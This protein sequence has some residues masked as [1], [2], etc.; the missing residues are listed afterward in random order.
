MFACLCKHYFAF[1][2]AAEILISG[3]EI[4][5]FSTKVENYQIFAIKCQAKLEI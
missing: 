1:A 2:K 3:I 4:L 5:T